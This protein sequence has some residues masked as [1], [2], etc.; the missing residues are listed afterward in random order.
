MKNL[1]VFMCC[2]VMTGCGALEG[3]GDEIG[4]LFKTS[5]QYREE[6]AARF[7]SW[8]GKHKDEL[9]KKVG[10]P[11]KCAV[12]SSGEESCEWS[13]RGIS[14]GGSASGGQGSSSF[15]SW[16]HRVVFTFDKDGIA[17]Q[18]SYNGKFGSFTSADYPVSR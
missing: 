9:I 10:P 2:F 12:L 6:Q 8:L 18:W 17:R 7:N 5:S 3:V 16:E 15:S 14:G 11:E 13:K 4:S 1:A